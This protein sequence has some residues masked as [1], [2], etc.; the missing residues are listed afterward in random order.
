MNDSAVAV[1]VPS[2]NSLGYLERCLDR[3]AD[4]RATIELLVVDN[5]ST[6]GSRE[7]LERGDIPHVALAAS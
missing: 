6:D 1:I 2:W 3:L 4:D 5:G 7:A